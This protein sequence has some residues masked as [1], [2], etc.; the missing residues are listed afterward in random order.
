MTVLLK[1]VGGGAVSLL[2]QIQ[3]QLVL[4]QGPNFLPVDENGEPVA[5]VAPGD[6]IA[7]DSPGLIVNLV[8]IR[9][10]SPGQP[11]TTWQHFQA[12]T[13][14]ADYA[15]TILRNSSVVS[16]SGIPTPVEISQDAYTNHLDCS[17]LWSAMLAVEASYEWAGAG[18][19]VVLV[20]CDPLGAQG[21]LMAARL[22][23]EVELI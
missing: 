10:G 16:N 14:F 18:V 6:A 1:D 21:G 4:Q 23:V 19:P 13:S 20:G 3:E 8:S 2:A 22:T 17:A 5:Y 9:Q 12:A 11:V 15:V 7:F